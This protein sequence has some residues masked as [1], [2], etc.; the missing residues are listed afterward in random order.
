[1]VDFSLS[2]R[3]ANIV[4]PGTGSSAGRLREPRWTGERWQTPPA[5]PQ[6]RGNALQRHHGPGRAE[7]PWARLRWAA[8]WRLSTR[9]LEPSWRGAFPIGPRFPVGVAFPRTFACVLGILS[10]KPPVSATPSR[11]LRL[12]Q[13]AVAPS[14]TR[15]CT[16]PPS[17]AW[18]IA[19][20]LPSPASPPPKL[21][22]CLR[23][24][25]LPTAAASPACVVGL[26]RH[27]IVLREAKV[28]HGQY[29]ARSSRAGAQWL[30][31]TQLQ[32]PASP[33]SSNPPAKKDPH[34][35]QLTPLEKL[36]ADAGPIRG[37][38]SDKFFGFENVRNLCPSLLCTKF[39]DLPLFP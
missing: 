35:P 10:S 23:D 31:C 32:S 13:C 27:D 34:A 33:A 6:Q 4:P 30:T 8:K 12:P 20:R 11:S 15:C 36:L 26:R 16:P 19:H 18:G 17:A 25:A 3:A 7:S 39:A 38:G 22:A 2:R 9:R 14:P 5:A 21:A 29:F 28:W 24:L 1:M 37:D